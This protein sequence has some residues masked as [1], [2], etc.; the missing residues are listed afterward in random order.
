MSRAFSFVVIRICFRELGY[1]TVYGAQVS[2][3]FLDTLGTVLRALDFAVL[4]AGFVSP[5][6]A[7]L[8]QLFLLIS[9]ERVV[10]IF[11]VVA[12]FNVP[13]C[14]RLPPTFFTSEM[15]T[16]WHLTWT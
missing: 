12:V 11:S 10:F 16:E 13:S 15:L 6:D 3:D 9:R 8:G 2:N 5:L 7:L 1:L 4:G 14:L